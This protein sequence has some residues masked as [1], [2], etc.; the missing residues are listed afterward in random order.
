M[1]LCRGLGLRW[2]SVIVHP[3]QYP[4]VRES[5]GGASSP[6]RVADILTAF[7]GSSGWGTAFPG[8]CML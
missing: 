6:E 1:S 2:V 8:D 4:T 3:G 5:E 7:P